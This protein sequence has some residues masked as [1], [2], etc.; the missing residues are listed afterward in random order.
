M[1]FISPEG[2]RS[3]QSVLLCQLKSTRKAFFKILGNGSEER[4]L[5]RWSLP[6]Y[7]A[8]AYLPTFRQAADEGHI[9]KIHWGQKGLLQ[10]TYTMNDSYVY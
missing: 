10:A 7:S 6:C 3:K 4:A 8:K 9:G 1:E 5:F 2:Q